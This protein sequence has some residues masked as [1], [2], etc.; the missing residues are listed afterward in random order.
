MA[1]AGIEPV[2][3]LVLHPEGVHG[4]D[5]VTGD[6]EV[7]GLLEHLSGL[8]CGSIEP[9]L[10]ENEPASE[11]DNHSRKIEGGLQDLLN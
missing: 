9:P 10:Q 8:G 1:K 11:A 4:P 6:C 2:P 7:L 3:F 5:R